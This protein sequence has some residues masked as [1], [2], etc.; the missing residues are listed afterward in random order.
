MIYFT[1]IIDAHFHQ[2]RSTLISV[3]LTFHRF[4]ILRIRFTLMERA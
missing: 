3:Q 1:K 2:F 4:L